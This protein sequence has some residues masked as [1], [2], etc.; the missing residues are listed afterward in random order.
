MRRK[1]CVEGLEGVPF[2]LFDPNCGVSKLTLAAVNNRHTQATH[3]KRIADSTYAQDTWTRQGRALKATGRR[4]E[5]CS[6]ESFSVEP[7]AC[8][9][10]SNEQQEF[11]GFIPQFQ[12][13]YNKNQ[14][15]HGVP[16][17]SD[18]TTAYYLK[19]Y[20]ALA[21]HR[22]HCTQLFNHGVYITQVYLLRISLL[23]N[24]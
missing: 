17:N 7:M 5:F 12:R 11:R 2:T 4:G 13:K 8:L 10:F 9:S 6:V 23:T 14:R 18:P 3:T 20:L 22:V 15:L 24:A 19:L 16:C 21:Q 1:P